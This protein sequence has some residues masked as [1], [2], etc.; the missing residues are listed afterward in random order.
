MAELLKFPLPAIF[1]DEE[2]AAIM[3]DKWVGSYPFP[4][5][6]VEHN[7]HTYSV[8]RVVVSSNFNRMAVM[9]KKDEFIAAD[10]NDELE[11]LL[12]QVLEKATR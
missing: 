12:A 9:L 7:E 6:K 10:K 2:A 1:I 3:F 4:G 11:K 5:L 8:T